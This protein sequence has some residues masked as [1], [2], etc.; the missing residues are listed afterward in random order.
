MHAQ[1]ILRKAD[2]LMPLIST[3]KKLGN[4]NIINHFK[5]EVFE[6]NV[7]KFEVGLVVQYF[8]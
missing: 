4:M 3:Y 8:E 5:L 7:T 2:F 1:T 6:N